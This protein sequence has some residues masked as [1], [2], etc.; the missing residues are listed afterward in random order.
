M[1]P[2][3]RSNEGALAGAE[4]A[5]VGVVPSLLQPAATTT[6]AVVTIASL[7]DLYAIVA[8]SDR[9]PTFLPHATPA[10]V[11]VVCEPS[12]ARPNLPPPVVALQQARPR[13]WCGLTRPTAAP[14]VR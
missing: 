8:S 12:T 10:G 13:T 3:F 11:L 2:I 7:K 4:V 5:C 1:S 6:Q 14:T 9:S